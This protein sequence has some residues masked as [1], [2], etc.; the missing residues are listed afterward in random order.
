MEIQSPTPF[1][2]NTPRPET[3]DR[4]LA[5]AAFLGV[6]ICGI[7]LN[8]IP[9]FM[10]AVHLSNGWGEMILFGILFPLEIG[11]PLLAILAVVLS[12]ISFS[13]TRDWRLI[14]LTL[15]ALPYILIVM[16]AFIQIIDLFNNFSSD[17]PGVSQSIV[18]LIMPA[19]NILVVL[20]GIFSIWW[21]VFDRKLVKLNVRAK[22]QQVVDHHYDDAKPGKP[23]YLLVPGAIIALITLSLIFYI[24][25]R[26]WQDGTLDGSVG[27]PLLLV[28]A[29]L[30][31]GGVFLFSYG[32]EMYSMGKALLL[33]VL[34]V[35]IPLAAAIIVAFL[36]LEFFFRNWYLSGSGT[37]WH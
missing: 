22:T 8:L 32:Y 37:W 19:T 24:A 34:I 30:C 36:V 26:V 35:F 2:S 14:L 17:Q 16:I 33:T 12:I 4:D 11:T 1:E 7:F 28:L 27:L 9:L 10:G 29:P 21:F 18:D 31:I 3:R 15:V 20:S 13:G 23:L 6:A 25:Y 5:F